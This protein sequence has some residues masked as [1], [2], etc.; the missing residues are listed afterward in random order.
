RS[1]APVVIFGFFAILSSWPPNA[2]KGVWCDAPVLFLLWR[3]LHLRR[4][5]PP[6]ID[7]NRF[8]ARFGWRVGGRP[9]CCLFRGW[10]D[11]AKPFSHLR[12][13][14]WG[15]LSHT[16]TFGRK[17]SALPAAGNPRGLAGS[18]A[19]RHGL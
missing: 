2:P 1:F 6:L 15:C 19:W 16:G 12:I 11:D 18:P 17:R 9:P 5:S 13:P 4:C 3:V 8:V 10:G 7:L 14:D